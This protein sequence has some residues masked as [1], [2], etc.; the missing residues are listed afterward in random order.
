MQYRFPNGVRNMFIVSIRVNP[1]RVLAT[2]LVLVFVVSASVTAANILRGGDAQAEETAAENR[3]E[4]NEAEAGKVQKIDSRKA[5]AK[6]D[7][8]RAEFIESFGWEIEPAPA[9]VQ[10]VIIPKEFDDVYKEYNAMQKLQGLDLEP[11]AGE[12]CKRYSFTVTNHPEQK[13][14][15]RCNLLMSGDK[16]VG[17]DICSL[18]PG[19]F[20]HGLHME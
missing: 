12:R 3:L 17:G 13:E 2:V 15:V 14:N 10:E 9:E 4:I 8:A 6:T 5:M 1:K 16:V 20:M 7:E 18:D 11:Y 19:G